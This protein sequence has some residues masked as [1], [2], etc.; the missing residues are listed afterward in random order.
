MSMGTT[1]SMICALRELNTSNLMDG[2]HRWGAL[3]ILLEEV[4]DPDV[5]QDRLTRR[6]AAEGFKGKA[7]LFS[8]IESALE[9]R[10]AVLRV[11]LSQVRAL[12][13]RASARRVL[14][15]QVR[16]RDDDER[17]KK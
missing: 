6:L 9:T 11:L 4:L 17:R 12:E 14:L 2:E 7:A 13:A 3:M 15:S 10:A 1:Y 5:D 16:A 8:A